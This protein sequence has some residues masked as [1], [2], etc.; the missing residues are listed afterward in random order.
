MTVT[1]RFAMAFVGFIALA[2]ATPSI[3]TIEIAK[4]VHMPMMLVGG[5]NCSF[6]DIAQYGSCSNFSLWLELG[7][8][9]FDTAWEY[10]TSFAIRDAFHK[11]GLPRSEVFVVT[12]IP[13]S[14]SFNCTSGKCSHFPSPMPVSGHYT[15]EMARQFIALDLEMLGREIGYIDLLLLHE[16]CNLGGSPHNYAECAKIYGVLEEALRNGTVRSIGVD[17]FSVDDLQQLKST[18]NIKPAVHMMQISL[19]EL[20]LAA[21]DWSKR[22]G[23]TAYSYSAL[24]SPCLHHE[25]VRSIAAK[26]NVSVYQVVL[27]W[28]VQNNVPFVTASNKSSH[29]TS[30]MAVFD[31]TLT[32]SEMSTLTA[33]KC[34]KE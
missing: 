8:K 19:G 5:E 31:Y 23:I 25:S 16:P 6:P 26:H 11:S 33:L 1:T 28:L 7:G 9:G 22:E 30:D 2:S 29:L 21:W 12:K 18:W 13:G 15:P 24:H 27:R 32:D 34:K 4:G 20:D 17:Q 3:P 10:Q 14:L